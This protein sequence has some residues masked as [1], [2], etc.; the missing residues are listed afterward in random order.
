M[1]IIEEKTVVLI[2]RHLVTSSFIVDIQAIMPSIFPGTIL[3]TFFKNFPCLNI[4]SVLGVH[5][6]LYT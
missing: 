5:A 4:F 3:E 2:N 1:F 6:C